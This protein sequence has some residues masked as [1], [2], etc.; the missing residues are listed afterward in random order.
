MSTLALKGSHGSKA[1]HIHA[2]ASG[3]SSK[4]ALGPIELVLGHVS[5]REG[6]KGSFVTSGSSLATVESHAPSTR[7]ANR[8]CANA[9][10]FAWWMWEMTNLAFATL[11]AE[12]FP[13]CLMASFHQACLLAIQGSALKRRGHCAGKASLQP[14]APCKDCGQARNNAC[15]WECVR[16]LHEAH[17]IIASVQSPR[18]PAD[19]TR[20]LR[21]ADHA[22]RSTSLFCPLS[23]DVLAGRLSINVTA[24]GPSGCDPL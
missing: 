20:K 17:L 8:A 13:T 10:N 1:F 11:L 16:S 2:L 7:K 24:W 4:R 19:G 22:L 14:C 21:H 5:G 18:F 3:K 9:S 23:I 15:S 6:P 12:V